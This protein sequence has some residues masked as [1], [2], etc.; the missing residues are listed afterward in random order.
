VN[1]RTYT[2]AYAAAL[3]AIVVLT[4]DTVSHLIVLPS[5]HYSE[6]L[7]GLQLPRSVLE[8]IDV[9]R[10]SPEH[11]IPHSI[12][13]LAVSPDCATCRRH[14]TSI[15]TLIDKIDKSAIDRLYTVVISSG[16]SDSTRALFTHC[17]EKID[18]I[19]SREGRIMEMVG[20]KLTPTYL[21]IT[22]DGTKAW[23]ADAGCSIS[24]LKRFMSRRR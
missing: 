9:S 16:E 18:R 2:F 24:T 6:A 20:I 12:L 4:V 14:V 7:K 1:V 3:V 11:S 21:M 13:V 10:D 8:V 5:T 17:G 22:S 23:I 19:L 15:C